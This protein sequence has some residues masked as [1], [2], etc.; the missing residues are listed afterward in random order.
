MSDTRPGTPI[1]ALIE[2]VLG[3]SL[4]LKFANNSTAY[5]AYDARLRYNVISNA[6]I[7]GVKLSG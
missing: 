5:V 3:A 1:E 4:A 6:V 2:G 7:G